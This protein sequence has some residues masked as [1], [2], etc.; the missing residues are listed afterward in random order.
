MIEPSNAERAEWPDA[1]RAYVEALEALA[2]NNK[3]LAERLMQ[4]AAKRS[5]ETPFGWSHPDC[6]TLQGTANALRGSPEITVE[7]EPVGVLSALEATR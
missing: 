5:T 3:R 6:E 7:R 4:M 1:T 2:S